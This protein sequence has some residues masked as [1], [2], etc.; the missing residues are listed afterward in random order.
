MTL[1]PRQQE[2]LRDVLDGLSDEEIRSKRYIELT[3][4]KTHICALYKI[5]KVNTRA[6]LIAKIY[7]EKINEIRK[8]V[9]G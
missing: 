7:K 9:G 4:I 2:I 5:F 6:K 3:T 1:T 8:I